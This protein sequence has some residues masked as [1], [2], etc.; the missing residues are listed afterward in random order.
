MCQLP[1][2]TL[3]RKNKLLNKY[4]LRHW[5]AVHDKLFIWA[6]RMDR[7]WKL[8][9]SGNL[10]HTLELKLWSFPIQ[11]SYVFAMFYAHTLRDGWGYEQHSCTL[12]PN[13]DSLD[14]C[15]WSTGTVFS[16]A[17]DGRFRS[18]QWLFYAIILTIAP[19]H[20]VQGFKGQCLEN[21][22]QKV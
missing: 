22:S 14:L 20:A 16:K 12:T 19:C 4:C 9:G 1:C 7:T 2:C 15:W 6:H 17:G 13:L 18:N 10:I 3:N 21:C 8:G 11:G 5:E